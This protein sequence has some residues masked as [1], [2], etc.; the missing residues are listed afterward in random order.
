[1]SRKNTF[2]PPFFLLLTFL[3]TSIPRLITLSV[4]PF[5]LPQHIKKHVQHSS[6]CALT[7]CY[8][9][10]QSSIHAFL[11]NRSAKDN[12]MPPSSSSLFV[13]TSELIQVTLHSELA[14][15]SNVSFLRSA[16]IV[17]AKR[18]KDCSIG[19]RKG[20]YGG[21]RFIPSIR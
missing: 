6:A 18:A 1:V 15:D 16:F 2:L 9:L 4:H 17:L 5:T 7:P 21:G 20:L 8:Q 3:L 10:T 19:K 11:E 12:R 14:E 13:A